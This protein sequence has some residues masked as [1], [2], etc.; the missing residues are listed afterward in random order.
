MVIDIKTKFSFKLFFKKDPIIITK[1]EQLN[2]FY[3]QISLNIIYSI[4]QIASTHNTSKIENAIFH[5]FL[6]VYQIHFNFNFPKNSFID[7]IKKLLQYLYLGKI[8][9]KS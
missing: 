7:L 1:V 9:I 4:Y 8:V 3:F 5:Y 6:V 2:K